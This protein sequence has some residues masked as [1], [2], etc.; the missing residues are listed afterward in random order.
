MKKS[1]VGIGEAVLK[2]SHG[3]SCAGGLAADVALAAVHHGETGVVISRI[4]QDE[5]GQELMRE[6]REHGIDSSAMQ[7]D[8][9]LPT[10]RLA[11]RTIDRTSQTA[12]DDW[13]AFDNLQ[14]DFDLEDVAHRADAVIVGELAR[15]G[16][17]TQT[18]IDRFIATCRHA[19]V[20]YDARH[21]ATQAFDRSAAL[22]AI[23]LAH[24]LV[25]DRPTL[26]QL[27]PGRGN[28]GTNQEL[29][30]ALSQLADAREL[31]FVVC[32]DDCDVRL[33][34]EGQ[35]FEATLAGQEN[36]DSLSHARLTRVLIE[37]LNEQDWQTCLDA[38]V[39]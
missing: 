28:V 19:L 24:G 31:L 6:F 30:T 2:T 11:I 3:K 36:H 5:V 21:R 32:I 34:A 16:S 22:R 26:N 20:V 23:E 7:Y 38:A 14:W 1:I 15:R 8:P 29:L 17:Q 33:V 27:V 10:G 37:L 35:V 12:I 18:T 25:V 39:A 9:D 13:A 4:G